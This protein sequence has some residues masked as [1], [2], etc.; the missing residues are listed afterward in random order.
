MCPSRCSPGAHLALA[1]VS[2]TIAAITAAVGRLVSSVAPLTFL[3]ALLMVLRPLACA[4]N[5]TADISE[6]RRSYL[7]SQAEQVHCGRLHAKL[8]LAQHGGTL[9]LKQ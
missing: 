9:S 7:K 6:R 4:T 1:V 3:I 2:A 5:I 8:L